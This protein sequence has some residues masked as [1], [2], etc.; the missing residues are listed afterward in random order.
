MKA[1]T[2]RDCVKVAQLRQKYGQDMHL[3]TWMS[4]PRNVLCTRHGRVF[5][6]EPDPE[7]P[8]QKTKRVFAHKQSKWH[9]PF[10]VGRDGDLQTVC[11]KFFN[12]VVTN[13]KDELGELEGKNLGCF[14]LPGNQCHTDTLIDLIARRHETIELMEIPE[15]VEVK[16]PDPK[17]TTSTE[18]CKVQT[19]A[20]KA[21][22]RTAKI[23]GYCTQHSKMY[24]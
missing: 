12:H 16:K 15:T 13:L 14:C 9:N 22:S 10:K 2:T 17:A 7:D 1:A 11:A 20:G 3:E 19:R 6:H 21:C 23:R 18:K 8:T 24:K 5:I 4:D